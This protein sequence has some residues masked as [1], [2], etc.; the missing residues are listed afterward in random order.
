MPGNHL[1][2]GLLQQV[3]QTFTAQ[4]EERLQAIIDGL[5]QLERPDAP[6]AEVLDGLF[7]AAH[8]IK[9]AAR[10]VGLEASA[11]L[12]HALED[13]FSALR[14]E[15]TAGRP[16]LVDLCLDAV[17]GLRRQVEAEA[18]GQPAP[19][20]LADL[21]ARLRAL[22]AGA[23]PALPAATVTTARPL[24]AREAPPRA[25]TVRLPVERLDRIADLAEELQGAKIRVDDHYQASRQQYELATRLRQLWQKGVQRRGEALAGGGTGRHGADALLDRHL[26][27]EGGDLIAELEHMADAMQRGLR[28]SVAQLR[29]LAAGL[30]E[31]ARALRMVP[32]D[33]ILKP[34]MLMVRDLA[35]ELGKQAELVLEGER[36]EM[37]RAVLD[38][39]RDPL[40]HLLRNALDH[41]IEDPALRRAAGKPETGRIRLSLERHGNSVAIGVADD[42]AGIDLVAVRQ[43]IRALGL[44]SDE[45]VA[46]LPP[47]ALLNYLF[48]P[49]FS[50]RGKV[51]K[52]SGRGVGLDVVQVSIEALGGR[53]ALESEIG[54]GSRFLLSLP[55]TLASD[56]GLLVR[57][58]GQVHALPSLHVQRILEVAADDVLDV[59]GG[60]AVQ[61][62]GEP[63]PLRD[64][65]ALLGRPGGTGEHAD[66]VGVVVIRRGWRRVALRVDHVLGEREMVVKPLAPPLNMLRHVAGGTLGRDG[67]II[68]VLDVGDLLDTALSAG[69]PAAT[70]V[71]AREAPLA[72]QALRIL[73]ADDSITTRT[74]EQGILENAGYRVQAVAD[75]EEAW[76]A[77]QN[78]HFDLLISD[79]EMPA[80]DGFELTRRVRADAQLANLP[81]VIV[82]SLGSEEHR[83]R[84]LEVRADAYVVKS[85]F[86]STEL[87]EVV[88]QLL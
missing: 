14:R 15:G 8:N 63:V 21:P 64:L 40:N 3:L 37:D 79:V 53:I 68:L 11:E 13:L 18:G 31:D 32:A 45:E 55:L 69:D 60:Q 57:V 85:D 49:G 44:A 36:L 52:V 26:L 1:D 47:R 73:V 86:E 48:R 88:K 87:L 58:A 67:D 54:H 70:R 20:G 24:A 42:G 9:G 71:V 4:L 22:A 82:T 10:G 41:G 23:A 74:L 12:A 72:R 65:A 34:L 28:T 66:P 43:R 29:P 61:V 17:S 62:D 16:G 5:L 59:A 78:G 19:D 83:R 81:V 30:R 27:A 76:E 50:T 84:G 35:R 39:L 80:L 2:P 51:G 77:L 25:T 46:A 75:G 6:H 56:H 7:R 33:S 38:S